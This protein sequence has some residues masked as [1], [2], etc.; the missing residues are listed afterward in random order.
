MQPAKVSL[1][2]GEVSFPR[3]G[4]TLSSVR[5]GK[6]LTEELEITHRSAFYP[7]FSTY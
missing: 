5:S 3:R 6:L 7:P 2:T 4:T 1:L